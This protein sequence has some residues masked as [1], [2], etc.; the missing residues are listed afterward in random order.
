MV[1]VESSSDD[2]EDSAD[3]DDD[4]NALDALWISLQ[5]SGLGYPTYIN[6]LHKLIVG[7][8][9]AGDAD[10]SGTGNKC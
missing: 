9:V 2:D 4:E 10:Y 7:L 5:V 8:S 3:E 1:E 6:A